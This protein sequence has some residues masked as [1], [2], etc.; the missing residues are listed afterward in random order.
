MVGL[1][2]SAPGS[3]SPPPPRAFSLVPKPFEMNH[4]M[5]EVSAMERISRTRIKKA[6]RLILSLEYDQALSTPDD[7]EIFKLLHQYETGQ[8][9]YRTTAKVVVSK[10]V[11]RMAFSCPDHEYAY[12]P[13]VQTSTPF[14]ALSLYHELRHGVQCQQGIELPDMEDDLCLYE[15][16]A[17]AAQVRFLVALHN[18]GMLP[19]RVSA[20]EPSDAGLLVQT[21]EAWDALAEG[22]ETF[23]RWYKRELRWGALIVLQDDQL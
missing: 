6:M 15:A 18:K 5:T 8:R 13:D 19:D 4:E 20:G 17:Y 3:G 9:L 22:E 14:L 23:C 12:N 11:G 21:L 1:V 7:E 10:N 2:L 16:P